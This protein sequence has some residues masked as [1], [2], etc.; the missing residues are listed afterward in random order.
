[1][2]ARNHP[3]TK[4][5]KPRRSLDAFDRL[6]EKAFAPRET[7]AVTPL[8]M[9]A[10]L[11]RPMAPEPPPTPLYSP[12]DPTFPGSPQPVSLDPVWEEVRQSK[13]R[14]LAVS[15]SKVRSVETAMSPTAGQASARKVTKRVSSVSFKQSADGRMMT[16]TF[17]IPGVRKQDMHVSFRSRCLV[18]SWVTMKV[19]EKREGQVL[20]RD[21][22]E[23]KCS[24]TLPLPE[25]TGFDEVRASRDGQHL[26]LT[27][28]NSRCKRVGSPT[29]QTVFSGGTEFYS[30]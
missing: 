13:E 14:E 5:G 23:R 19:T 11:K 2:A 20:V 29:A 16:A 27:Y 22:E 12:M 7:P 1:M 28:P 8:I 25:G 6:F 18:V 30:C 10:D 3:T 17:E 24:H 9:P 26:I 4:N 21:R 15:P